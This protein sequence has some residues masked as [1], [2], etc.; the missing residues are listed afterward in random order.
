[1]K[2]KVEF[3]VEVPDSVTIEQAEEWVFFQLGER[4]GMSAYNPLADVDIEARRTSVEI[5]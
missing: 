5:A 3:E 2:L 1:M 4:G